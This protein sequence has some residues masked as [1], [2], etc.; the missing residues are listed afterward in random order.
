MASLRLGWALR[1][2]MQAHRE[3]PLGRVVGTVSLRTVPLQEGAGRKPN[4]THLGGRPGTA[5]PAG[6]LKGA[7]VPPARPRAGGITGRR[8]HHP[9]ARSTEEK[10]L[11]PEPPPHFRQ[12]QTGRPPR[13][14]T[15]PNPTVCAGPGPHVVRQERRW[16]LS[17]A[18]H[19]SLVQPR[20]TLKQDASSFPPSKP[21][22]MSKCQV[23]HSFPSPRSA[24]ASA[25]SPGAGTGHTAGL[26]PS[27]PPTS[28]REPPPCSTGASAPSTLVL[29]HQGN[30]RD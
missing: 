24:N 26:G 10:G 14:F 20:P 7:F 22:F 13:L 12:H 21:G 5:G 2:L 11:T 23:S 6:A 18:F 17:K 16:Q 1:S 29:G 15:Q 9:G 27:V 30:V 25:A 19:T 4:F 8:K 28:P 3:K